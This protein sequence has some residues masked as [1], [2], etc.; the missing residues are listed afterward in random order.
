MATF[1]DH[2]FFVKIVN[3]FFTV[4]NLSQWEPYLTIKL[5]Q[6]NGKLWR[7]L[8]H[9]CLICPWAYVYS[10]SLSRRRCPKF[11]AGLE[12]FTFAPFDLVCAQCTTF[13]QSIW[14]HRCKKW[15]GKVWQVS[16]RLD[17]PLELLTERQIMSEMVL[18]GSWR[19]LPTGGG[20]MTLNKPFITSSGS[21]GS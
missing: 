11:D 5:K 2:H 15:P 17:Q 7:C 18:Q 14:W 3:A 20:S 9:Y 4:D 16:A 12:L 21:S 13:W 8:R 10:L 6:D 19:Y 1:L